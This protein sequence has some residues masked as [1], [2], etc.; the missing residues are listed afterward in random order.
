MRRQIEPHE[1]WQNELSVQ[2]RRREEEVGQI[3]KAKALTAPQIRRT[4]AMNN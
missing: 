1:I 4:W 3:A 2:I